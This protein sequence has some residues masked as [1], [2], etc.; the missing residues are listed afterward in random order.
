VATV[1]KTLAMLRSAGYAPVAEGTNG[2]IVV[3]RRP[4]RRA[5]AP[6][7]EQYFESALEDGLAWLGDP[8]D[9]VQL[10]DPLDLAARLLDGP[11][12]GGPT[13]GGPTAGGSVAA[14]PGADG[15]TA[16][17]SGATE[18]PLQEQDEIDYLERLFHMD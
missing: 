7:V 9:V 14:G 17:D 1:D 18:R 16:R 4:V 10:A 3:E 8:F 11:T 15:S 12:A 5:A 6:E 13:A 2:E